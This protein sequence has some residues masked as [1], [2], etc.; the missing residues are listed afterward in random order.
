[1]KYSFVILALIG[2]LAAAPASADVV[3]Y[4]DFSNEGDGGAHTVPNG[5]L[6]PS[7]PIAGGVAPNDWV[8][9]FNPLYI[10]SDSTLNEFQ[11][12]GGVM[13]VQDWGGRGTITGSSWTATSDGFLDIVGTGVTLGGDDFNGQVVTGM[14][15]FSDEGITWFYSIN[16]GSNIE[17]FLGDAELGG[18]PAAGTDVGHTFANIEINEGDVVSYGFSVV[19]EGANTGVLISSVELDFTAIPEPT[20]LGFLTLAMLGVAVR[21]RR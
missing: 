3:D 12:V 4:L 19:V 8:L 17:L 21:R 11:V 2:L 10:E 18:A 14:A 15:E 20:G 1:M 9:E 7:S 13:R 5:I 16:G 6:V